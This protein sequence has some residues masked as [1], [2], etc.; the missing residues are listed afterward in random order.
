M[1]Y[2]SQ[3][4]SAIVIT[5]NNAATL[6]RALSSLQWVDELLVFDRGSTDD[7]LSIARGFTDKVFYHPS[8]SLTV[9]RR[10]A[11]MAAKCDWLL[12]IEPDEWVEEMLRH[13]IDGVMLNTPANLNGFMLP[14]K[15]K[16][17]NQWIEGRV[18]EEQPRE[19]RLVRKKHWEVGEDWA[20]PLKVGG[21]VGRLDRPI[22]YAPYD[23]I[24]DLF[25]AMNVHSTRGA[26]QY[27]ETHGVRPKDQ[28]LTTLICQTKRMMLGQYILQG[29]F[30][31]GYT[32][33][34]FCMANAVETFL[35]FAKVRSLTKK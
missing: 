21:D 6:E 12:L 17:Q 14:R 5:H 35:K 28:K 31:R 18:G 24:E 3:T 33:F 34:S 2:K 11:L 32:G 8:R 25:N 30:T 20:A 27:L 1:T 7:T 9:L 26:Y 23:N 22:G 29:G 15:L 4:V 13:E 19:V 16:F 10:D